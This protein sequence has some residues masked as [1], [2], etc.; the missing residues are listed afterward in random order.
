MAWRL[1][2]LGIDVT[3]LL[4]TTGALVLGIALLGPA[5]PGYAE[6]LDQRV[7]VEPGGSLQV[8][9]DMGDDVVSGRVSLDVRSHDADEVWAV[10]DISGLGGSAVSFRLEHDP[11]QVRLYGRSGGVM[12][13]LFGG[14]SVVVRIWV[15]RDFSLDLRCNSGAIRVEDVSGSIRVRTTEAPIEIRATEGSLNLRSDSGEIEVIEMLG[16]VEAKSVEGS[17]ELAWVTGTVHARTGRGDLR[18]RH[19]DGA[20]RLRTG[21][22]EIEIREARGAMQAKTE[23]GAV[24][25]SFAGAPGG[26]L[27]TRRGAV[28]VAFPVHHGVQLDARTE[29]GTVEV[30]EE[31][32]G[33]HFEGPVNGGGMP[34]R[35]Y[36]ARG[37]IRVGRR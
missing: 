27:E 9:L 33:P 17:I 1:R 7:P 32:N 19:I 31:R 14:P 18:L 21:S 2:R 23:S 35:I 22:G 37:S 26:E 6:E 5:S 15:P 16:D 29:H 24:Y 34:L 28:V 3:N 4:I 12:S 10:A 20:A 36:T 8:D 25:A 13:W 11:K 30:D